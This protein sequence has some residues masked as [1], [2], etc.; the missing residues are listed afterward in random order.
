MQDSRRS[1]IE[2]LMAVGGFAALLA[3]EAEGAQTS[4]AL[5]QAA[6]ENPRVLSD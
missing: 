3:S 4:S 1:F 2:E 5:A 6:L